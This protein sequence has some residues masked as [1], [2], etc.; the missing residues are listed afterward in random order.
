MGLKLKKN[1]N[2]S[3]V[4]PGPG[5]YEPDDFFTKTQAPFS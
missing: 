5:T 1:K 3:D 4:V 2:I